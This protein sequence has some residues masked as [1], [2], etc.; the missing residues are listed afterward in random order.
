MGL[1]KPDEANWKD[2]Q[3]PLQGY[4]DISADETIKDLKGQNYLTN[5][6][7]KNRGQLSKAALISGQNNTDQ[8]ISKT[9]ETVNNY[10]AGNRIGVDNSNT[11]TRFGNIKN[12]LDIKDYNA[13]A[14]ANKYKYLATA[15]NDVQQIGNQYQY[16]DWLNKAYTTLNKRKGGRI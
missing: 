3:V 1:Q 6:M 2:Y 11:S 7:L 14:N 12:R 5:Y 16:N 8:N 13:K 9:R 15:V 10:N 4:H